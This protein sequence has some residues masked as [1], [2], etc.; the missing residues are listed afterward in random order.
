MAI[1]SKGEKCVSDI[2]KKLVGWEVEPEVIQKIIGVL[3]E[4]KFIDENRY[5]AYYVNDKFKFN[6]W[7]K[8]KIGFMLKAK[9]IPQPIIQDALEQIKERDYI[10]TLKQLLQQKLKSTKA[11]SDYELKAKLVRFAQGRGF[12]YE[13]ISKALSDLL[14]ES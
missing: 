3:Q 1:C 10:N 2:E 14:K 4:E 9:G 13:A 11:Q 5:V 7:G 8:I 12:E 6:K